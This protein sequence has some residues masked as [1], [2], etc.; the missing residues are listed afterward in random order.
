MS[1]MNLDLGKVP[2][3]ESTTFFNDFLNAIGIEHDDIRMSINRL[4]SLLN[5][6]QDTS[7]PKDVQKESEYSNG[8]D[9]MSA[10]KRQLET[11]TELRRDL[12]SLVTKSETLF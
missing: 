5:R 4:E 8:N 6:V 3:I 2:T 7:V 11:S 9:L 12:R 1:N 10:L